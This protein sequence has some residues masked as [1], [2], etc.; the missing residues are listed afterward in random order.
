ML[1]DTEHLADKLKEEYKVPVLPINIETMSE[2]KKYE[3]IYKKSFKNKSFIDS[4]KEIKNILDEI[5]NKV[6]TKLN[7]INKML[8]L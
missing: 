8:L 7:I 2:I 4:L 6:E 1:P 3:I 5:K